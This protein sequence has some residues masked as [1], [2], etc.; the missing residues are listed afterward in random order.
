LDNLLQKS[1]V[2]LEALLSATLDLE[3]RQA[4]RLVRW[5]RAATNAAENAVSV[6]EALADPTLEPALAQ[7]VRSHLPEVL[8]PIG[9]VYERHSLGTDWVDRAG[10]G[11]LRDRLLVPLGKLDPLALN[12]PHLKD[13]QRLVQPEFAATDWDIIAAAKRVVD[14][15]TKWIPMG[16]TIP[17]KWRSDVKNHIDKVLEALGKEESA[18]RL[19]QA[20]AGVR[21]STNV[22][23]L[24][25]LNKLTLGLVKMR[26]FLPGIAVGVTLTRVAS[27]Y[28]NRGSKASGQHRA[29]MQPGNNWNPISV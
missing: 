22:E 3:P 15:A 21:K 14:S 24:A 29:A 4:D 6:K 26:M 25:D 10:L 7:S 12:E 27:Y 16:Q 8:R 18:K 17:E 5:F 13:F 28:L 20:V 1:G 11:R 23:H 2:Y 19:Y 9:E